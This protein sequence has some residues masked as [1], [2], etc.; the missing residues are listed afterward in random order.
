MLSELDRS[1]GEGSQLQVRVGD[2]VPG[3]GRVGAI[4][5]QGMAWVVKT[6]R[7]TIQ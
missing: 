1:G 7:G 3:Y 6:D 4:Q 2:P 5:Q